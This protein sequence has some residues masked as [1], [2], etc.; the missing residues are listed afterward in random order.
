MDSAEKKKQV[1]R[2]RG[3]ASAELRID[4]DLCPEAWKQWELAFKY[5][6]MMRSIVY[7]QTGA[8]R[9][10]IDDVMAKVMLALFQRLR[11]GPLEG[12]VGPY[13]KTMAKHEAW[14]HLQELRDRAEV[15]VG[16]D[17]YRL[18]DPEARISVNPASRV[19]HHQ[20]MRVLREE[21]SEF[22][23]KAF[24]LCEGYGLKAPMV[25]DLLGGTA[26]S[27]SVRDALR[28]AR[29]KLSSDHVEF[30]L[31]IRLAGE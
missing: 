12:A 22:Q 2:Q 26:T 1:P 17:T 5:E 21:L 7:S 27:A 28:H 9:T 24:V 3:L 4:G 31:G 15:F 20:S 10:H 29:R 8:Q 25:A 19:E 16:D 11:S 23:L 30:R 6:G 13:L 14:S 18:E